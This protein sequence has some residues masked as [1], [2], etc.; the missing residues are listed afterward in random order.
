M[1]EA[2]ILFISPVLN[3]Q[4]KILTLI[5]S[6]QQQ[7]SKR[8]RLV[9]VDNASEDRTSVLVDA[10]AQSDPRVILIP[11]KFRE[12]LIQKSWIRAIKAA[13]ENQM[14]TY[15][16]IIPGD[17]C[18]DHETYV[19]EM[20]LKLRLTSAQGALPSFRYSNNVLEFQRFSRLSFYRQW[21]YV[22]LI[23][24]VYSKE[25]FV[26]ALTK[27]EKVDK[28]AKDFDWW[29]AF[30]LFSNK[31][32]V[33]SKAVMYRDSVESSKESKIA[34][35][36]PMVILGNFCKDLNQNFQRLIRPGKGFSLASRIELF[37]GFIAVTTIELF[38][39]LRLWAKSIIVR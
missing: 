21:F 30:F 32:V 25:Y 23:F 36:T 3:E 11:M 33:H 14:E 15:V 18:L 6:L 8:W 28:S 35:V 19:E 20:L 26:K 39:L 27:F 16:Q 31:L 17:D 38:N 22:H 29:L 9:V 37:C 24:G 7:S 34:T 2:R 4:A 10:A 1:D 12:D 13:M 5:K